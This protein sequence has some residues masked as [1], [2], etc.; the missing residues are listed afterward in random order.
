[1]QANDIVANLKGHA[2][3]YDAL[4]FS[5]GDAVPV[6]QNNANKNY[7]IDMLAVV[8]EFAAKNKLMIGHC[9]A[10]LIFEI[11]GVTEGK[12]LSVHPL[13]KS[14]IQKGIATNASVT[15]DG[16]YYTAQCEHTVPKLIEVL[17]DVLR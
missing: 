16:N 14:A 1:M 6:F 3:E 11:A 2:D 9:A 12:K 15:V 4:L 10:A 7:N 17:L 5:C 13:A 8:R